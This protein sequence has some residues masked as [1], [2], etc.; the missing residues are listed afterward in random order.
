[1]IA[2]LIEW[3]KTKNGFVRRCTIVVIFGVLLFYYS[4]GKMEEEDARTVGI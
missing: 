3:A 1:V 2:H 4:V